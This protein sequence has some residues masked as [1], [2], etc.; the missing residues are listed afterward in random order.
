MSCSGVGQGGVALLAAIV[1]CGC[2]GGEFVDHGVVSFSLDDS[3]SVVLPTGPL[4]DG[5]SITIHNGGED[6]V[7]EIVEKGVY[8]VPVFG[9]S[10]TGN[11]LD[12][13]FSGVWT[14]SLRPG[15]YQV[16]V[17]FCSNT[18][19]V[20]RCVEEPNQIVWNTSVGV[21]VAQVFCDSLTATF[22]TPTGDYRYLSG[23]LKGG[24]LAL[25]TFDGAHLFHFSA[26]VVGDSLVGGVF[27]S[28]LHYR[29]GWGG[30]VA[31]GGVKSRSLVQRHDAT[32]VVEFSA[33]SIA[34]ERVKFSRSI[35]A[36]QGK[37]L[38]VIDVLGSW[39]P[40][41]MDEVRLI[42]TLRAQ[43]P[44]VLFVS[45]AFERGGE[46]E[47]LERLSKFQTEM[48]IGWG[49]LYGGVASKSVAD[50][51]LPFLGGVVSFP[52]TAFI[53]AVGDPVIHSGFNGPATGELYEKE[54]AFFRST[55]EGFLR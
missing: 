55:I 28:G 25:A 52:T 1:L 46:G 49:L 39:C 11:W 31:H 6:I 29:E 10:I 54:V 40:N 7:L 4:V 44:E 9:G 13:W 34:G 5:E 36:E 51:V 26:S 3:T 14:D 37:K 42:K 12:G 8:S 15:N 21:L 53:P 27:K 50:S 19:R 32:H 23:S 47:S 18:S 30:V 22:I 41:C 38:M 20:T 43:Y 35:L 33:L 45:V 24:A 48:G 2:F 16:P 17:E